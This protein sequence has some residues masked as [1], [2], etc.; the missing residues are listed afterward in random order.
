MSSLLLAMAVV[1]LWLRSRGP[2]P[3]DEL[4]LRL[5]GQRYTL[6]SQ[7]GRFALFRLP[8]PA[9]PQDD[10]QAEYWARKLTNHDIAWCVYLTPK[11][12]GF[13]AVQASDWISGVQ[14]MKELYRLKLDSLSGPFLDALEDPKR[15]VAAHIVLKSMYMYH[16]GEGGWVPCRQDGNIVF[17]HWNGLDVELRPELPKDLPPIPGRSDAWMPME[18]WCRG[19]PSVRI[20]PAQL[21]KIRRYW[22]D[23]LAVKVAALPH[24]AV[25]AVLLLLPSRWCFIRF[26]R[27]TAMRRGLCPAC[28]YDLRESP[29]RCPECGSRAGSVSTRATKFDSRSRHPADAGASAS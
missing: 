28:R 2:Y 25:I 6:R 13:K 29:E 19:E 16:R 17:K 5:A 26:R 15:F 10:R 24:A 11:S 4:S 18:V 20:D 3:R 7:Q 23:R 14:D 27:W 9:S 1:V 8:A 22:H 12:N 21:P